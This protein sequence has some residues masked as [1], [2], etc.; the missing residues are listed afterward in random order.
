MR[1]LVLV[2]CA[3]LDRTRL[4]EL[5]ILSGKVCGIP[6]CACACALPERTRLVEIVMSGEVYFTRLLAGHSADTPTCACASF[7]PDEAQKLSYRTSCEFTW[8]L[9]WALSWD[10]DVIL[11]FVGTDEAS[12][13]YLVVGGVFLLGSWTGLSAGLFDGWIQIMPCQVMSVTHRA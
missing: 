11:C 4:L 2:C 10:S 13:G 7:G 12:R 3:S 8:L 1:V 5:I 6:T 9:T